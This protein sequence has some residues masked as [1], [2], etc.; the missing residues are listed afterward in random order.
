M[1]HSEARGTPAIEELFALR[2]YAAPLEVLEL[3]AYKLEHGG[4]VGACSLQATTPP[5]E[6]TYEC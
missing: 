1:Q 4:G 6:A 3:V 5:P 2:S